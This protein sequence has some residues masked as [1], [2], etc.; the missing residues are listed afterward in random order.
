MDEEDCTCTV[1]S[2][3]VLVLYTSIILHH[4]VLYCTVQYF[5]I[6]KYYYTVYFFL[7]FN[8]YDSKENCSLRALLNSIE[9][10]LLDLRE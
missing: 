6:T 1:D 5:I 7:T 4:T 2:G 3:T 9:R 10:D 8:V